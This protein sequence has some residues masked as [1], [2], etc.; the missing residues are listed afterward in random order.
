[1]TAAMSIKTPVMALPLLPPLPEPDRKSAVDGMS[2]RDKGAALQNR[3]RRLSF[4]EILRSAFPAVPPGSDVYCCMPFDVCCVILCTLPR[5]R[6]FIDCGWH[7]PFKS[8]PA[9]ISI[10][11][12]IDARDATRRYSVN[13]R[14]HPMKD[15][16]PEAGLDF[17]MVE[18]A[19][20]SSF[21]PRL[22][23]RKLLQL[24]EML[25]S[26]S[27]AGGRDGSTLVPV[28]CWAFDQLQRQCNG[29]L[30]QLCLPG[31]RPRII[32]L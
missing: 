1:M 2:K 14:V 17:P 6:H 23:V 18:A 3:L 29:Q 21:V 19:F 22:R 5:C 30:W 4:A 15:Y 28:C 7:S 8:D 10:R 27:D 24:Y 12:M 26:R 13:L 9:G 32:R 11:E 16:P 20:N 31:S 25:C